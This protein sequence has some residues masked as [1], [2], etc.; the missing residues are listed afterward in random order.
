[1]D[2]TEVVLHF[3]M[4]GKFCLLF[5]PIEP[6]VSATFIAEVL[7]IIYKNVYRKLLG[8]CVAAD[9][10][11]SLTTHKNSARTPR[12]VNTLEGFCRRCLFADTWSRQRTGALSFTT[13]TLPLKKLAIS[14]SQR[15]IIH[16]NILFKTEEPPVVYFIWPVNMPDVQYITYPLVRLFNVETPK[17]TNAV[18]PNVPEM[19]H[20]TKQAIYLSLLQT[21]IDFIELFDKF[22]P[23][24]PVAVIGVPTVFLSVGGPNPNHPKLPRR[25]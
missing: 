22:D 12:N 15:Y 10:V 9:D 21:E 18:W 1:M 8:C 11:A 24:F 16:T 17:L 23:R 20:Y 5:L 19:Y 2:W 4:N 25:P 7:V 14:P 3:L 13:Q 6:W